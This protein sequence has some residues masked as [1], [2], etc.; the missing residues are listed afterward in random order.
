[1]RDFSKD[2]EKWDYHYKQLNKVDPQLE[3][4]S[5]DD[6]IYAVFGAIIM[7]VSVG[8]TIGMLY[9]GARLAKMMGWA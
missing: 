4:E 5:E 2:I 8:C 9:F 7:V 6:F 1:M 3:G